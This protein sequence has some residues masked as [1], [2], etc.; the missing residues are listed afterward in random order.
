[1]EFH[2]CYDCF[3]EAGLVDEL[4]GVW[5]PQFYGV[6][7]LDWTADDEAFVGVPVYTVYT[8]YVSIKTF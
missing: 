1:M 4:L 8:V 3:V 6:W 7:E 5:V 2:F